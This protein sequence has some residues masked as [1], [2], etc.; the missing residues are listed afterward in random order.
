M[1]VVYV[2]EGE[3]VIGK[4]KSSPAKLYTLLLLGSGDGLEAWNKSSK[5]FKFV[6]IAG[7]PLNEPVVQQGP[8][9]MN[10]KEQIEKTFRDFHSYTNGFQRAKTW[11]SENARGFSH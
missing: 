10:T 11:K 7:Q 1:S 4:K 5:P 3:G 2:L 8:F 9:V 6:L